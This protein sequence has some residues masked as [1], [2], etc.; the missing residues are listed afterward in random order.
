[1]KVVAATA[2]VLAIGA[3]LQAA[4]A[5]T[6]V[7]SGKSHRVA[8]HRINGVTYVS[9]QALSRSLGQF[10][11]PDEL[12]SPRYSM[13]WSAP[14]F[15]VRITHRRT[16]QIVQSLRPSIVY[17]GE[18][19]VPLDDCMQHLAQAGILRWD[20]SQLRATRVREDYPPP[21]TP[22]YPPRYQL[23]PLLR[24]PSLERLRKHKLGGEQ[25]STESS[26][27][28]SASP[29]LASLLPVPTDPPKRS[30]VRVTPT[31]CGDTTAIVLTFDAAV[32]PEDIT[33]NKQGS[34]ITV[35]FRHVRATP[36]TFRTLSAVRLRRYSVERRD[37]DLRLVL[38]L[39]SAERTVRTY[40][41]SSRTAVIEIAP[42]AVDSRWV[43]DCIVLDAGH[44]GQDVGTIGVR[45]TLEKT[46]SLAVARLLAGELS[47][48][49]PGVR[50]VLTRSND[51]FVE[52]HRRG[53]IANRA[54][55]KL[56]VSLHCNAAPTKPH[57]ARGVEVYVLSPARTDA[58]AA[59]AARENASI[60]LEHD[61]TRYG[62]V[63]QQILANVAQQGFLA[64]SHRLAS[65]VDSTLRLRAALPSRGVHSAGFLVLVG[66]AMPSV[67]VEMGFLS[68]T[69]DERLLSSKAGQKRIARALAEAIAAY[70]REYNVM[71]SRNGRHP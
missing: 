30:V 19:L 62:S 1:M 6:I 48:L 50:V 9:L 26:R 27:I 41:R 38:H 59:V 29:L 12:L 46:V 42:A 8:V 13:R 71:I 68:N 35:D 60:S 45:G 58:A 36:A 25:S 70:V 15:F 57:P 20:A 49:L 24:R 44:G 52:L 37:N 7:S 22:T 34:T 65:L 14:G 2:M 5:L 11:K 55:G 51:S 17:R 16:V 53:E 39:V 43:I 69:T 4:P 32:A 67:L 63:E 54:G 56:F 10:R 64:L 28:I 66:A 33:L 3:L 18:I 21:V 47:T 31:F 23:P 40:F 61:S